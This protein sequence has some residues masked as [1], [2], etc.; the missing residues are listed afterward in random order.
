[1]TIFSRKILGNGFFGTVF[2][3]QW[4]KKPC[5]VKVLSPLG[6][7]FLTGLPI[8][9]QQDNVQEEALLKFK[10]ECDFMK[11]YEHPNIV[12]YYSTVFYPEC[13]LPVLVM[14]LMQTSLRRYIHEDAVMS[15]RIQLSLSCDIASALEF[16]HDRGLV[17]RDLCGDNILL[18]YN[19]DIPVAKVSDFGISRIIV[20]PEQLS[21]SLTALGHRPGYL[22]PEAFSIDPTDYDSSLD[23]FMFGVV[24]TQIASNVP[25]VD[26]YHQRQKL[27]S[28]LDQYSLKPFICQCLSEKREERPSA[29]TLYLDLLS[30]L[31]SP[32]LKEEYPSIDT[33]SRLLVRFVMAIYDIAASKSSTTQDTICTSVIH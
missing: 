14:E 16:L 27:V 22:P 5:A 8:T 10:Q 4:C 19:Q 23:I 28:Q 15:K 3:G 21:H 1:L 2:E 20:K 18:N 17:H 31:E 11:S 30:I 7:E 26:S 29:S 25:T 6:Q 9:T 33:T 13:N 32:R 24:M 12:A